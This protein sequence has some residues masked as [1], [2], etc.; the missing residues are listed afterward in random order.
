MCVCVCVSASVHVH[1]QL[2]VPHVHASHS[3]STL[4]QLLCSWAHPRK[5]RT[6]TLAHTPPA[7]PDTISDEFMCVRAA[8][9]AMC[10]KA[11]IVNAEL[12]ARTHT[13]TFRHRHKD[14]C[15]PNATSTTP[16]WSAFNIAADA[17][18]SARV[19]NYICAIPMCTRS[20]SRPRTHINNMKHI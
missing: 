11:P 8:A 12:H 5:R 14:L 13:R 9:A 3:P 18:E 20:R 16:K 10:A 17:T 19:Q 6:H 7:P 1:L 15:P 4:K 2:R